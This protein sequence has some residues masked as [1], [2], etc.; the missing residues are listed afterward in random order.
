MAGTMNAHTA[1]AA[2]TCGGGGERMGVDLLP[3]SC[4]ASTCGLC[5]GERWGGNAVAVCSSARGLHRV[6]DRRIASV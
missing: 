3:V 2:N 5:S 6:A 4:S 1:H